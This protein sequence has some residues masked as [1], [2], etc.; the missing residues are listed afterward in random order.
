MNSHLKLAKIQDLNNIQYIDSL[1]VM[2]VSEIDQFY[3]NNNHYI[4]YGGYRV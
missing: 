4:A 3:I 2:N 1:N